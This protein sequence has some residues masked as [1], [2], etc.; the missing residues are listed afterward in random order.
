MPGV[1][2]AT[3]LAR[4]PNGLKVDVTIGGATAHAV[5]TS[6]SLDRVAVI[7]GNQSGYDQSLYV[8]VGQDSLLTEPAAGNT[9]VIDWTYTASGAK[10]AD[11]TTYRIMG[12]EKLRPT[13]L[14]R[15]DLG[16]QYAS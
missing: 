4:V 13:T 10:V 8:D 14:R 16:Q 1:D 11:G 5:A 2:A 9:L 6:I 3:V 7:Y 12:I 15:L